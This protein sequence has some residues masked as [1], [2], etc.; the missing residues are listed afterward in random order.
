MS[1]ARSAGATT[2]PVPRPLLHPPPE[3]VKR[4]PSVSRLSNTPSPSAVPEPSLRTP[5]IESSIGSPVATNVTATREAP[6]SPTPTTRRAPTSN[7]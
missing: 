2:V 3:A 1:S 6:Q 4:R 7:V 5:L